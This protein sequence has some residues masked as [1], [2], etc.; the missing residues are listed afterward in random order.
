MRVKRVELA[1]IHP[2]MKQWNGIASGMSSIEMANEHRDA[3]QRICLG[4]FADMANAGA[5]VAAILSACYMSGVQHTLSVLHNGS[6]QES[7]DDRH[8]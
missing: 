4:I 8:V 6:L 5:P 2:P 7:E 3:V 1:S